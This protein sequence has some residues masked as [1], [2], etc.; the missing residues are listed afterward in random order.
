MRKIYES[1]ISYLTQYVYEQSP[2][3]RTIIVDGERYFLKFPYIIYLVKIIDDRKKLFVFAR[4]KP[5]KNIDD[6]LCYLPLPNIYN[7]GEVCLDDRFTTPEEAINLFWN[8]EFNSSEMTGEWETYIAKIW[9]T[10]NFNPL[11]IKW[12]KVDV[13]LKNFWEFNEND[14]LDCEG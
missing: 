1:K 9:K 8:S 7:S 10:N 13:S 12:I 11:K 5:L 3:N 2:T 6:K 14:K 4:N